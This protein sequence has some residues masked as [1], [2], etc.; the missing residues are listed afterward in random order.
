MTKDR[1]AYLI[2]ICNTPHAT[3]EE[4][5]ELDQ[6]Y[7]HFDQMGGRAEEFDENEQEIRRSRIWQGL[8]QRPELAKLMSEPR[9]KTQ[10]WGQLLRAAVVIAVLSLG[11]YMYMQQRV[12]SEQFVASTNEIII[13]PGGN[14]AILTL[15]NGTEVD[16]NTIEVG[17]EIQ[18]NGFRVVKEED[19]SISYQIDH[20]V[21]KTAQAEAP[22]N[23]VSTPRGGQYK[24]IL[25]DGSLV[26]LNAASSVRYQTSFNDSE[27][28]VYLVGEAYF[29]I[30]PQIA[31][32]SDRKVPF[33]VVTLDQEI[34]VLGTHFNVSAYEDAVGTRTTLLEGKVRLTATA[35]DDSKVERVLNVGETM[36][37]DRN[38]FVNQNVQ[39]KNIVAWTKGKFVFYGENIKDIMSRV[40]RWYDVDVSYEG[41]MKGINF[42]GSLSQYENINEILEKLELTGMIHFDIQE[43][44]TPN[45]SERRVK[46]MR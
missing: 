21:L 6:W 41:N 45:G 3:K 5:Y 31:T 9:W 2:D 33:I 7:K 40:S 24:V 32:D 34:E 15:D 43:V 23:T 36:L 46:V 38:Q 26:W 4:R 29:E 39:A 30:K 17:E 8:R 42:T 35:E 11:L 12:D 28:L 44:K 19:G 37:W 27:R 22:F 20:S 14:K 1:L 18:E 10:R 13:P 25:P 16:L